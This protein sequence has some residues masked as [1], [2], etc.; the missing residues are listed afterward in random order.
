MPSVSQNPRLRIA[1]VG[2]GPAGLGALIALS[3][4]EGVDVQAYEAA[5]ELREVGAVRSL[6]SAVFT[7]LAD[8]ARD[9]G[10]L[11]SLEHLDSPR[12]ARG[13][14]HSV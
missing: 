4:I 13:T 10:D 9:T 14:P 11:A 2:A 1:V 3:K 12:E 6:F 5:R 7:T 8:L